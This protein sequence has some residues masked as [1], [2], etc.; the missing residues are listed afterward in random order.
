STRPAQILGQTPPAP[1]PQQ[2]A[3]LT[4]FDPQATWPATPAFLKSPA[5]NTPW[6]GQT[7]RGQILKTW[8]PPT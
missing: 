3:E 2:P 1:I 4:L 5:T 6:L 8:T 7:L